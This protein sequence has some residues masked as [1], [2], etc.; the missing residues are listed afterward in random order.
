MKNRRGSGTDVLNHNV[1]FIVF[2]V[3]MMAFVIIFVVSKLNG[4][5]VMEEKYCKEIAL[6][7]DAAHPGMIISLNMSDAIKYAEKSIGE[8]NL[9]KIVSIK[10]N[11]V[12]V[13]LTG[14]GPGYTYSFFNN[15]T[16]TNY[17][18]DKSN[19]EFVFFIGSYK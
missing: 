19:N 4:S 9:A 14:N 3:A 18:L 5:G 11:Q 16:I 7:L 2:L 6:S 10:G 1:I 13:K 12:T 17:Y 8:S 15:V